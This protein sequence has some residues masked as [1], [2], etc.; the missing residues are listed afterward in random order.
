MPKP[1]HHVLATNPTIY[2]S[3]WGFTLVFNSPEFDNMFFTKGN[4]EKL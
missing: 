1:T 3:V 4:W 2:R